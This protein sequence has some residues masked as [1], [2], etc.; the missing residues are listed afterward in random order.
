MKRGPLIFVVAAAALGLVAYFSG[1]RRIGRDAVA[2]GERREKTFT[3]RENRVALPPGVK[4]TAGSAT[5]AARVGLADEK[6]ARIKKIQNDYKEITEKLSAEFGAGGKNFPGGVNAFLRQIALIEREMRADIAALLTPGE[7]EDFLMTESLTGQ[8][9]AT[10]LRGAKV[11]EEQKREVF[12]VQREFD[13]RYALVFDV[14]PP[15]LLERWR[16]QQPTHEKIRR[17]LG[18]EAFAAWLRPDDPSYAAMRA[19]VEQQNLPVVTASDLWRVKN[20]WTQRKLEIAAQPGLSEEQRATMQAALAERTRAQV[21]GLLGPA[22]MQTGS[23]A[24]LWL[25]PGR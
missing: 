23:D 25:P 1:A 5:A 12:R 10:R 19:L 13:E 15:A 16:A 4:S 14:A 24:I 9:L 6:V 7:L 2:E 18:D 21:A 3:P 17:T 11:T 8:N 20:E 22:A